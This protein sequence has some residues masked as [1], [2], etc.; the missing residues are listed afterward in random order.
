MK[1]NPLDLLNSV[2][3]LLPKKSRWWFLLGGS[4]EEPQ[5][6][7]FVS[8]GAMD[9]EGRTIITC[10]A[11]EKKDGK[12]TETF[13]P[14]VSEENLAYSEWSAIEIAQEGIEDQDPRE[15]SKFY[16][17]VSKSQ[18]IKLDF[19]NRNLV[20]YVKYPDLLEILQ[21]FPELAQTDK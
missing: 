20:F 9:S 15:L 6:I 18:D 12:V 1:L 3:S 13:L 4:A 10:Y 11:V 21:R 8:D 16:F 17:L 19:V 5:Y 2:K 14:Q 7:A